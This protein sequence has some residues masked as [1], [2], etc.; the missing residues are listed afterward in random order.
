MRLHSLTNIRLA[1]WQRHFAAA[2]NARARQGQLLI[3]SN[4]GTSLISVFEQV[5][6]L[7]IGI[8]GI[9]E[10][11]ITLGVLF[12]F[13]SLRGRLSTASTQ[14]SV[15][16]QEFFL[17]KTH[18]GRLSDILLAPPAPRSDRHAITRPIRGHLSVSEL[19]FHYTEGQSVLKNFNCVVDIG[20]HVAV[21]GPSGCGKS[22]LLGLLA[23]QLM[24]KSGC[25]CIDGTELDLWSGDTLCGAV[26]VVLQDDAL[27]SGSIAENICGFSESPD[28][29]AMREAAKLAAIWSD[30]RAMPMMHNTQIGDMQCGLSGGQR[31]RIILARAFYR[32]PRILLLDEATSHLDGVNEQRVLDGIDAIGVTTVSVTHRSDVMQRADRIIQLR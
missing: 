32:H 31:Q 22:T 18:T 7:G 11:Q 20:E 13:M 30:I 17:L 16:L 4:A 3:W 14:L 27:F 23:G 15:L 6:F 26:T 9:A 8:A 2:T 19:N 24:P 28:M 29:D 10:K 21:T 12:A 5:L 1:D 25:I